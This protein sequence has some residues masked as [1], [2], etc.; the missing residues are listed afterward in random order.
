MIRIGFIIVAGGSGLRMGA[1]IPKQFLPLGGRPV[2]LRTMEAIAAAVP[3]AETVVVLPAAHIGTL[4]ELC[5]RFGC[6][7][8]YRAT[9][10]GASRFESVEAGLKALPDDCSLIAVHDGVRPLVTADMIRR[11]L[12]CARTNR[13]AVPVI[14][15]TDTIREVTAEGSSHTIDRSKLRAVQTPQIF[16]GEL[17]RRAYRDAAAMNDK[18]RFTDDASV[19]EDFGTAISL[20]EGSRENLKLTTPADMTIAEAILSLHE[21]SQRAQGAHEP[22]KPQKSQESQESQES[23]GAQAP[24]RTAADAASHPSDSA[25]ATPGHATTANHENCSKP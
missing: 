12:D 8:R 9:A 4:H 25:S 5:E 15:V 22:Q 24:H 13:T 21:G 10:G 17:L 23:H 6:T 16:D 11:G 7:V 18:S 14:P 2:L 19:V 1:G 3:E 20:Y